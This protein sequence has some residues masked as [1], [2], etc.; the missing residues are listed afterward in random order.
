MSNFC[1]SLEAAALTQ[2]Q[3]RFRLTSAEEIHNAGRVCAAHS[4]VDDTN[5]GVLAGGVRHGLVEPLY[6]AS[7]QL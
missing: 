7:H 2:E 3:N 4:V 1:A 6:G 5:V